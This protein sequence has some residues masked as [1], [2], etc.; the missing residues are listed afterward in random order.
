MQ[1]RDVKEGS[2]EIDV[3]VWKV[4]EDLTYLLLV[5]VFVFDQSSVQ[6]ESDWSFGHCIHIFIILY[7]LNNLLNV[8]VF[9]M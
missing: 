2:E 3:N 8:L 4:L 5:F 1:R 7:G 6:L 9:V